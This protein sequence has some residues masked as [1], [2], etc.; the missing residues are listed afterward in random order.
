M[1]T[2]CE[3]MVAEPLQVR[4]KRNNKITLNVSITSSLGFSQSKSRK[5]VGGDILRYSEPMICSKISP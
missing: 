3:F 2:A 4:G 5:L 1:K